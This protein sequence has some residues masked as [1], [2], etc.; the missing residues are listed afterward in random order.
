MLFSC[1]GTSLTRTLN[2]SIIKKITGISQKFR[3]MG[4]GGG[5][6]SRKMQLADLTETDIV[7][8]E[9]GRHD[10]REVRMADEGQADGHRI[11]TSRQVGQQPHN[12]GQHLKERATM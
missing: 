8:G 6:F 9:Q 10:G 7:G 4:R 3:G 11:R 1:F 2:F 5:R 12:R